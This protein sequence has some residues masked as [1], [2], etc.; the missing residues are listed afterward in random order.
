MGC[1]RQGIDT[2]RDASRTTVMGSLAAAPL[3]NNHLSDD[4]NSRVLEQFVFHPWIGVQ[5]GTD[6]IERRRLLIV[7]E[8]HYE[9]KPGDVA[10]GTECTLTLEVIGRAIRGDAGFSF[11]SKIANAVSGEELNTPEQ[12]SGFWKR[13][14]FYN[15]VKR[16]LNTSGERPSKEDLSSGAPSFFDLLRLVEPDAVLVTG[17]T[18]WDAISDFFPPG[19][20][21]T[22]ANLD[23]P[24]CTYR[25]EGITASPILGTFTVHPSARYGVRFTDATWQSRVARFVKEISC[26]QIELTT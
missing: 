22:R 26:T 7:G 4:L 24:S 23:Q 18:V 6:G 5:Y 12:R 19:A 8:S 15:Y 2:P 20:R 10:V 21:S 14:T 9:S 1:G 25:W 17:Q 3:V 11:Y 16:L 13:V